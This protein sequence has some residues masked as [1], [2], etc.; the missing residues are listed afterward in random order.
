MN[1]IWTSTLI[2]MGA[3]NEPLSTDFSSVETPRSQGYVFEDPTQRLIVAVIVCVVSLVG[4]PGNSLV[5]LAVLLSKKLHNR[6][7]VFV[8]NLA[9]ADFLTCLMLPFQAVALLHDSWPL[10]ESLCTVVAIV[11]WAGLGSSV[12]NL[13]V[14][15][16]MRFYII[17]KPRKKYEK[18]F[19][20]PAM[21]FMVIGAW[22]VP[23]LL[24]FV[25]PLFGLGRIGYSPRYR[26]CSADSSHP[27]ADIYAIL[28]SVVVEC[29][30]LIIIMVCYVKIYLFVRASSREVILRARTQSM[31][32]AKRPKQPPNQMEEAVFRRQLQV[33]QNLFVVVCSYIICIMPF[34]LAC[35]I[36]APTYPAIPWTSVLL[37]INSCVNPIIYGLKHPQF[38]EV[39]RPILTCSWMKIPEPLLIKKTSSVSSE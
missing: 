33:T 34:G 9:F 18:L 11:M 29:P 2:K 31:Q 8:V 32:M 21:T 23:F 14:I 1:S 19:S 15:A 39:F 38:K 4:L 6:T 24:I 27:L 17:T 10:S 37:M 26:I 7:N 3:S 16:F 20:K 13:A 36:P 22:L 12:V 25:P 35:V 28:S 5:M 30:G